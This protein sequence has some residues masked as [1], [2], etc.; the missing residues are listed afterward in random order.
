MQV[1]A[2]MSLLYIR[3]SADSCCS[4]SALWQVGSMIEAWQFMTHDGQLSNQT[5][6]G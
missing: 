4:R 2:D 3:V 1:S 6:E 5:A